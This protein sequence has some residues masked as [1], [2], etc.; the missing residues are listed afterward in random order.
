MSAKARDHDLLVEECNRE[1]LVYDLRTHRAHSLNSAAA[2]IWRW[3]DGR[4][5]VGELA[6]RLSAELQQ[7]VGSEEVVQGLQ[8]LGDANLLEEPALAAV[9]R[10]KFVQKAA[11]TAVAGLAVVAS[12]RTP[13]AATHKSPCNEGIG[14][15]SDGDLND[16][17][18]DENC[19]VAN[20][21]AEGNPAGGPGADDGD[22]PP[23][24][25]PTPPR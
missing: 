20:E 23:P 13:A 2:L 7:P 8:R 10:R 21:H 12:I 24:N 9:S 14:G 16:G 15:G 1:L 17:D 11:T 4:T 5:S 18:G 22:G 19:D 25:N 3:C 6:S